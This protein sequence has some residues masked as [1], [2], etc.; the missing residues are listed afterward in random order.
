MSI[1]FDYDYF[2][3][4]ERAGCDVQITGRI[5][6]LTKKAIL[7]TIGD[8]NIW[9]PLSQ[10]IFAPIPTIGLIIEVTVPE[11]LAYDKGLI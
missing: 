8:E 5:K 10:I 4:D 9:L 3:E 1:A 7:L 2:D 11:W 6:A